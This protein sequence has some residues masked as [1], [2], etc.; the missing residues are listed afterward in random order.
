MKVIK[1]KLAL[2]ALATTSLIA[3][4]STSTTVTSEP[5]EKNINQVQQEDA[6]GLKARVA[7]ARFTDKS[8]NRHWWSKEIGDG[9]ADQLTTAL[10]QTNRF[11]VLERANLD[12]VLAE[13]DLAV[14][15]RVSSSTAAAYGEI[16]GAEIVVLASVTEFSDDNSGARVGGSGFLGDMVQSVSAGFKGTH[17]AIDLRLVDTRTSRILSVASVEGGSKDF[18]LSAAAYNFGGS[19][20]GSNISGWSNTPKEKALREVISKAVEHM[21]KQIPDTYYRYTPDNQLAA[22][23]TPPPALKKSVSVAPKKAPPVNTNRPLTQYERHDVAMAQGQ[24]YCLGYLDDDQED[25]HYTPETIAAIERFQGHNE[26][27]VTG[28]VDDITLRSLNDTNCM[29]KSIAKGFESLGQIFG[30]ASREMH[31]ENKAK[32]EQTNK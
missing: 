31:Q 16:E 23:A 2:L 25:G 29:G 18:N 14:A 10:V 20:V 21:L 15:G 17:M 5:A 28:R 11:I 8:N 19:L 24:L 1:S 3:C 30:G 26:L 4:S 9:M 22:G 13:Q 6:N 7:V 32:L 27:T 12:V